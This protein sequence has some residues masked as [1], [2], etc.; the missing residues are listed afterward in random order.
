M[1]ILYAFVNPNNTKI[2]IA[3]PVDHDL[4]NKIQ[5]WENP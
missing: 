1:F 5:M 3:P 2:K 4:S